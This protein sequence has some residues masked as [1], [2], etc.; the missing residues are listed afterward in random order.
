MKQNKT[1]IEKQQ[2]FIAAIKPVVEELDLLVKSRIVGG[3]II[4]PE[5]IEV[6]K[7]SHGDHQ[8]WVI[9]SSV[10]DRVMTIVPDAPK[11]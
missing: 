1:I 3:Y 8:I 4:V 9:H 10:A 6:T 2:K 7:E 5:G 11:N